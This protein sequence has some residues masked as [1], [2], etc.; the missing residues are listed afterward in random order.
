MVTSATAF[1]CPACGMV[2]F[3]DPHA[4]QQLHL[5]FQPQQQQQQQQQSQG[6]KE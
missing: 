4:T 3:G 5:Q 1:I 6:K 2:E